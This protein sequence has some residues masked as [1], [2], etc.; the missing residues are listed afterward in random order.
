MRA[1]GRRLAAAAAGGLI[2]LAAVSAGPWPGTRPLPAQERIDL[3]SVQ[4]AQ[5]YRTDEPTAPGFLGSDAA[6]L[7]RSLARINKALGTSLRPDGRLARLARW[8]YE[9]RGPANAMPPQ[10]AFDVLTHRLGLV[11]PLPHLLMMQAPDAPRLAN[12]VSAHLAKVFDLAGYTHIGGVAEMEVHGVVVVIALSRRHIQMGPVPRS[13]SGPGRITL[14]GRVADGY[15]RPELAH[16]LPGG[17]TRMES[18]GR[19]A[20]FNVAVSLEEIGRH[21]LE[22]TAQGREGPDVLAN[23]PVFVGVPADDTAEAAVLPRRAARPDEARERLFDLITA[24]RSRARLDP[25]V[26]D[27]E[28]DEVA[29]RHS[30]DMSANGFVGHVS[31]TTGTA[32]QRLLRAGIV[33]DLAAENVAKGY[34]IDEIHKGFMDSPGHRAAILLPGATHVGIGIVPK[35]ENDRTTYFATELFIRRIPPLGTD[36][37]TVFLRELNGLREPAGASALEEDPI[38][39]KLAE[40]TAL[41]FLGDHALSQNDVLE[42]LTRRLGQADLKVHSATVVFSVLGS[43]EDGAKQAAGDPRVDKARRVG[44]GL[45]QGTRPGLVP[46]SIVLVVIFAE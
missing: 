10:D 35:R 18:L 41:E 38:L 14:E 20:A 40:A 2:C 25:L 22:I 15:G 43:L 4:G 27:P 7:G 33:T 37:K 12:I 32:E 44:I 36:A 21:R 19:G 45:A 29:A 17:E 28:L 23:F 39:T 16:T 6:V 31:P 13:L 8:V 26:L 5:E 9:R 3:S 1:I 24:E 30:Q 42:R 11:E 46:N 34:A